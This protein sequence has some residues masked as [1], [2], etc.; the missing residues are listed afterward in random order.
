MVLELIHKF[1]GV[2]KIY[3]HSKYSVQLQ[4]SSLKELEVIIS[5]FKKY[6][7]ITKKKADFF[8]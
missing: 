8:L 5:H 2:G 3:P 7:L 4:I 1:I 6:P